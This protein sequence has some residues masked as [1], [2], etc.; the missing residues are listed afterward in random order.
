MIQATAQATNARRAGAMAGLMA[1]RSDSVERG[2]VGPPAV[3]MKIAGE[4]FIM[5]V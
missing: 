3:N 4:W 2:Q 5:M 1:F